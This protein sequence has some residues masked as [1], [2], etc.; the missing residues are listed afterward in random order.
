MSKRTRLGV[1]FAEWVTGKVA[2]LES[3]KG[4]FEFPGMKAAVQ[5]GM[6]GGPGLA[7]SPIRTAMG[8]RDDN[9]WFAF[10]VFYYPRT[11]DGNAGLSWG[12][13]SSTTRSRSS[14]R[15]G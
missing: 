3:L 11:T 2:A 8:Q 7:N 1:T 12:R 10:D 14:T 5:V 9:Y 15:Q 4:V 13:C 6:I